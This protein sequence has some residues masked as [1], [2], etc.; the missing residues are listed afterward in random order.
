MTETGP[1]VFL[2]DEARRRKIG[3]VGRPQML[4][5]V[6]IA[7]A[8]GN[9]I[10]VPAR[11][12][13]RCAG[14]ASRPATCGTRPQ[15][16]AAFTE[17]GWFR[18]GESARRDTDGD[19]YIVD[20]IKDMYISGGENVYPAEVEQCSTPSAVL[21]AAVIG[22][23]MP[24]GRGR[25]RV[26]AAA[27]GPHDRHGR[28]ARPGAGERIAAYKIPKTSRWWP[29]F[30]APRPGRCR[31]TCSG[32]AGHEQRH[33]RP[34]DAAPGR[35]DRFARLSG[36]DNPIHVDPAFSARTRFGRTVAHGMLLYGRVWAMIAGGPAGR[37]ARNPVADV[38]GSGLRGRGA[39]IAERDPS[40]GRAGPSL[41]SP[42][43]PHGARRRDGEGNPEARTAAAVSS[44]RPRAR[45]MEELGQTLEERAYAHRRPGGGREHLPRLG[46]G[47]ASQSWPA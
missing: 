40:G 43:A 12:R 8:M 14:P 26:P 2:A 17:D 32:R 30:R 11:A 19:Y 37:P 35:F 33:R 3:S 1:T 39:A 16:A 46:R 45:G 13:C 20:R 24:V 21:E 38:P 23:P 27:S 22:V 6:R 18:S 28:L 5:D 15:T 29:I 25:P 34:L 42:H 47:G 36:D 44:R 4:V 7:D 41:C 31:S 9:V 10:E